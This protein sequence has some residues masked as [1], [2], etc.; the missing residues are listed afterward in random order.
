MAKI[1]SLPPTASVGASLPANP[2]QDTPKA[3]IVLI[4]AQDYPKVGNS[5]GWSRNAKHKPQPIAVEGEVQ[6]GERGDFEPIAGGKKRRKFT[7]FDMATVPPT[8]IRRD[9]ALEDL[10][11]LG[12]KLPKLYFDELG[13]IRGA[14]GEIIF[15]AGNI[16]Q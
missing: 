10:K 9:Y 2:S 1:N 4:I 15:D 13:S 6:R 5:G 16:K 8:L 7:A 3:G 14:S 11:M 12:A